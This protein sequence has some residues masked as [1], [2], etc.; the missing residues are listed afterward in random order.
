MT[1]AGKRVQKK[2]LRHA[3]FC[4]MSL[5]LLSLLLKNSTVAAKAISAG[6]R[7][8]VGT[9]IPSLFPLRVDRKSVV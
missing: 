7:L 4:L 6:L 8:C 1:E 9:L 5:F 2:S 3:A